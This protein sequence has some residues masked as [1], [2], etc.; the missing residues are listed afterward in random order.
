MKTICRFNTSVPHQKNIWEKTIKTKNFMVMGA[1]GNLDNTIDKIKKADYFIGYNTNISPEN[2]MVF[3]NIYRR[4]S[5]PIT[6]S[7]SKEWNLFF[8]WG[9]HFT[10]DSVDVNPQSWFEEG[11]RDICWRIELVKKCKI[12]RRK[13]CV[14]RAFGEIKSDS[15]LYRDIINLLE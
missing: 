4:T 1:K 12:K 7:N 9:E 2:P 5:E 8:N 6:I 10:D 11:G 3:E 14:R 13:E 15:D